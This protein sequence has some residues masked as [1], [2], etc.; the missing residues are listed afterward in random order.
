MRPFCCSSLM[1][2]KTGEAEVYLASAAERLGQDRL[3][4]ETRLL[5]GEV[6]PTLVEA[7]RQERCDLI[8]I[9]SHGMSGL[10]SQVFG[11]VAQKLLYSAP[12]PVLVVRSTQAQLEREE[13]QEEREADEALLGR[14][15]AVE[16][17]SEARRTGRRQSG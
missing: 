15:G 7:A 8:A 13:E 2:P 6:A 17:Q 9:S 3:T 10:V 4:V 14:I 16:Q 1:R 5:H 11:S 12:C